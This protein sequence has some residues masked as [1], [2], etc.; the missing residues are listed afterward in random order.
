MGACTAF[1]LHAGSAAT[2]D[3]NKTIITT[4]SLGVSPGNFAS[5]NFQLL[6][7]S[8]EIDSTRAN[9]CAHD[10]ITAYNALAAASCPTNQTKTELS[11]LT[12]TPGVYCSGKQ[13]TLS[14]TTLTLDARGN[15]DAQWIFQAGSSLITS[16]FTSVIL[17][18]G[19]QAKNV[20]W[21]VGSSATIGYSSNF[22]GTII[23]YA[24]IT[25]D[26]DSTLIGRALCGAAISSASASTIELTSSS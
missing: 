5:G 15:S 19:A 8:I 22:V 21:K 23:A 6:D 25:F 4:G 26:H 7:G 17:T 16:P 10:R 3:G 2:F 18:N 20:Y 13:L 1:A 9:D 11:G 12:L 24:S 14:A